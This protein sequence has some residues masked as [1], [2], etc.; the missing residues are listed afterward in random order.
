MKMATENVK[1]SA[2]ESISQDRDG[3]GNVPKAPYVREFQVDQCG[4]DEKITGIGEFDRHFL[5]IMRN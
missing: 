2:G 5:A 4:R 3:Q 1:C